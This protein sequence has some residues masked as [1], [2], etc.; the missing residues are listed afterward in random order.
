MARK[1]RSDKGKPRGKYG[2]RDKS[3][4]EQNKAKK[5]LKDIKKSIIVA[6]KKIYNVSQGLTGQQYEKL[7]KIYN[8]GSST[9][10]ELPVG[11]DVLYS[12][13]GRYIKGARAKVMSMPVGA[14][15]MAPKQQK[16]KRN[17]TQYNLFV[18]NNYSSAKRANPSFA[19]KQIIQYI[20]AMWRDQK[21]K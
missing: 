17:P 4:L 3:K 5:E 2:K 20:S 19:P 12:K 13:P 9:K 11:G 16:A 10:N 14:F 15:V 1:E 18:K 21:K 7:K 8:K 6:R